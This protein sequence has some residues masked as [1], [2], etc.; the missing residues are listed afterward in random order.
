MSSLVGK[1]VGLTR[2]HEDSMN[3]NEM[4]MNQSTTAKNTKY[5]MFR[6]EC[7]IYDMLIKCADNPSEYVRTI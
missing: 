4:I 3:M 5:R 6:Q 1:F 2:N 7:I